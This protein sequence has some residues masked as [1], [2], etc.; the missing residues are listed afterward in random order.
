MVVAE[1]SFTI[2][3]QKQ[4][5][6]KGKRKGGETERERRRRRREHMTLIVDTL[7]PSQDKLGPIASVDQP[8]SLEP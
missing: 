7:S 6:K 1:S 4:G 8:P 3:R 2:L 5:G